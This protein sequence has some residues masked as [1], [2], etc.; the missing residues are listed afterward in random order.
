MMLGV[1]WVE[2]HA[3]NVVALEVAKLPAGSSV[4]EGRTCVLVVVVSRCA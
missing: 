4:R 2:D 3:N 1:V